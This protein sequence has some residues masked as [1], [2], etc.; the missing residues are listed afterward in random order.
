M[1]DVVWNKAETPGRGHDGR[2]IRAAVVLLLLS[3]AYGCAAD[4]ATGGEPHEPA[5]MPIVVRVK[6]RD[7][8]ERPI[9]GAKVVLDRGRQS[10]PGEAAGSATVCITGADGDCMTTLPRA[11][12]VRITVTAKGYLPT[13][14][15][16][17]LASSQSSPIPILME[18]GG[19]LR[20]RVV[21]ESGRGYAG[22]DISV[23]KEDDD[24][25]GPSKMA[26]ALPPVK[27]DKQG[28]FVLPRISSGFYVALL[29]HGQ[30]EGQK[31][32]ELAGPVPPVH[33]EEEGTA[34][35]TVLVR[36][37]G[38]IEGTV[39]F[40]GDVPSTVTVA[41]VPTDQTGLDEGTVFPHQLSVL[42]S[43]EAVVSYALD[44]LSSGEYRIKFEASGYAPLL[45]QNNVFVPMSGSVVA[46][47][48]SMK[49]GVAVRGT[50]RATADGRPIP[51]TDVYF[52]SSRS[53][54]SVAIGTTSSDGVFTVD[55]LAPGT[56]AV[57][58]TPRGFA[59]LRRT[60]TIEAGQG[61][62]EIELRARPGG[63]I[64][65]IYTYDGQPEGNVEVMLNSAGTQKVPAG[66]TQARTG[67]DGRF[68]FSSLPSGKYSLV[69][70]G[71]E[72]IKQVTVVGDEVLQ[73]SIDG[74]LE[75]RAPPPER[76]ER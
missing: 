53:G 69:L 8:R 68:R 36:R 39:E 45:T 47:P 13:F 10:E 61:S 76:R 64:E 65:G 29:G 38:R 41:L 50:L 34:T 48:Q 30:E 59:E 40:D 16:A 12:S 71:L 32:V 27:T 52:L 28:A 58:S 60:V 20:G 6:V 49:S 5:G 33:V 15:R 31:Q 11:G 4:T 25:V 19:T 1:R 57:K 43:G 23:L 21:D 73:V 44:G 14:A 22:I 63:V 55:H 67:E 17:T 26:E 62:Q 75:Q 35:M 37:L 7:P 51:D 3:L 2:S 56:Y 70:P 18:K 66:S 74:H 46:P 24:D 72:I 54:A 9:S 42:T